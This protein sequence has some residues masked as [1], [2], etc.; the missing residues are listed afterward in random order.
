MTAELA[1]AA[2]LAAPPAAPIDD[3][4]FARVGPIDE[5]YTKKILEYTTEPFFLTEFV[6]YLPAHSKVPTPEKVLGYAIGTPKT[7]TSSV[8][9]ARY[10]RAIEKATGR[11]RVISMGT[12][13]EGRE[14]VVAAISDE[15]NIKRLAR[16]KQIT[17][18]LGDPRRIAADPKS[19]SVDAAAEALI[20]EGVPIYW[21]TGGLH[22]PETGPPEMILELAYRL[23]VDESEFIKGIRKNSVVMLT[24]V[25]EVDGRDRVVDLNR[26]RN[27]SPG[28]TQIPLVY[29]GHYVA[30]DNNRDGMTLNLK[31]SQ[32]LKKT[33]LDFKPQV[34]HDL[35]ESVAFLYV[36]T[37]T[38]PYNAWL[39]PITVNEWQQMAYHEIQEMTK[40]GVPGVW[41]HDFFDGWA[42]NYAF[43]AAN[44]HNA[45]GRFYETYGGGWADTEMRSVGRQTER[46]WFRPNPPLPR[47]RW[48]LRNNTNLMQSALLLGLHRTATERDLFLRNYYLKSK[49]SIAK[50]RT[51]GPAA[52]VVSNDDR[53]KANQRRLLEVLLAQGVEVHQLKV[54]AKTADGEFSEGSF[55][56]RMDQPYSRMA[57]MMLDSQYYSPSDPRSYDDTG[58]QLGPLFD[59]KVQR[60]KDAKLLDAAM[61]PVDP[62][63]PTDAAF[64][65]IGKLPR[66]ALVHTWTS[67]QDEGWYRIALDQLKVPYKYVSVHEIRDNANLR[68]KFDVMLFPQA[69]GSAQA[70]VGGHPRDGDPIPWKATADY[71]NLGGPDETDNIRGGIELQGLVNLKRF[72]DDGGLA[73]F[74]GN[75]ARVPIDFG[76]ASGVSY[77][78][79]PTLNAPGGVFLTEN[80]AKESA[81]L[82]GYCESLAVYFNASSCPILQIGAGGG[83]TTPP[84]RAGQTGGRASGRGSLTDPD[85][86][87][88]R[89]PFAPKED[90]PKAPKEP[91]RPG[92]GDKAPKPT[93]L[94]R[95]AN[96]D[97][98]LVSG[99]IDRPEELAGKAAHVLVPSGKGNYL[100]FSFNPMWRGQTIGSYSL[101]LNSAVSFATL[102]PAPS[103]TRGPPPAPPPPTIVAGPR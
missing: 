46:A 7:L 87:Q 65:D 29:W 93:V 101:V 19:K 102:Q 89:P 73:I 4:V 100:L 14:M 18:L 23:A 99:M 2:L 90:D 69:R 61:E 58:W 76:M 39:D 13:E 24:P 6:D 31:L 32:N 15:S 51:E 21:A 103:P 43:Y 45:V 85:V 70:L 60:C 53:R 94:L 79:N 86:I 28:R 54:G 35:H 91:A 1:L 38:G 82:S 40:R 80:A 88:G 67:T 48:S 92:I 68:E 36:S 56:V 8:D 37:G 42:P 63:A 44:G 95:F 49:R 47:V 96:A 3:P 9:C 84:G 26:W 97:K 78:Q 81:V 27:A 20:R 62:N 17:G 52:Y 33:R 72:V 41:T 71:P 5:G 30:H 57:D 25:L 12:S 22:S 98:V 75:W 66:I 11:L 59:V 77:I 34:F 10:L 50:A 83:P 74:C 64:F 16:L 55:V